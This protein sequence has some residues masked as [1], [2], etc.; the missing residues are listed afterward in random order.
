MKVRDILR[1]RRQKKELALLTQQKQIAANLHYQQLAL[2]ETRPGVGNDIAQDLVVSLTTFNKRINDVY[3]TIESLFQQSLKADRIILWISRE[4]FSPDDV[5]RTLRNLE[6]RGLTIAFCDEDLGPYKKFYYAVQQYPDSLIVTVDDDVLY[7][8]D[9]LDMLYRAWQREPEIV[10]CHR[11]HK[12]GFDAR[13]QLV[14]Y[15]RWDKNTS[16]SRPSKLIMPTGIGGVLYFPGCFHRELLNKELFLQIAPRADDI[17]LKAM[18]LKQGIACRKVED[19]RPW[20]QRFLTI[21]NSQLFALK[22]E[23]MKR[24]EGNDLKIQQTF[25]HFNLIPELAQ[26]WRAQQ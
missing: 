14:P 19:S 9:T 2:S 8:P 26:A 10:H 3:L 1:R 15:R 5:P 4:E 6:Q 20:K 24:P 21:E 16:D 18:T 7:P 22:R 25:D 11:A 13:G 17:W 12:I 23:N